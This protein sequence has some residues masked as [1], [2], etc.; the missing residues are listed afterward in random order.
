M[1]AVD[2]HQGQLVSAP[3]WNGGEP[4]RICL[5]HRVAGAQVAVL[6]QDARCRCAAE[7]AVVPVGMELTLISGGCIGGDR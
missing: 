4:V 3:E 5:V 1:V 6:F 7:S 2:L